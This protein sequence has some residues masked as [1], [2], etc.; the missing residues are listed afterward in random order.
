MIK[1]EVTDSSDTAMI[2]PVTINYSYYGPSSSTLSQTINSIPVGANFKVKVSIYNSHTSS[3]NPVVSGQASGITISDGVT[4]PVSVHCRP[5]SPT[6]LTVGGAAVDATL[7]SYAEQWYS[8]TVTNGTTYY[9]TQSN[10]SCVF[11]IFNSTGTYIDSNTSYLA[12]T[13]TYSGT[14]YLVAE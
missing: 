7:A 5:V 9:I 4:T 2:T 8:A 6:A 12:Y 13:A 10:S 14:L 3:S 11:G 1:I